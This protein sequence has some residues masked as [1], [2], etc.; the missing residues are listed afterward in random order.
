MNKQTLSSLFEGKI[1]RVPDYQRGYAW[2]EKQWKDFIEDI[3]AL[4]TDGR[5]SS[6]YTGTVVTYKPQKSKVTYNLE[7]AE[8][9]DVVDGQQ[10]LTTVSLFLSEIIRTLVTNGKKDYERKVEDFLHDKSMTKL[11]LN[12]DTSDIFIELIKEGESRQLAKTVHQER[13]CLAVEYF[14]FYIQKQLKDPNR[15]IIHIEKLF[16][17]ITGKMMFTITQLKKNVK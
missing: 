2:E 13:L 9:V 15:G 10:R 14:R 1:F 6:H 4:V 11:K 16:K 3:D 8:I 7:E 17:A 5:I 12:N